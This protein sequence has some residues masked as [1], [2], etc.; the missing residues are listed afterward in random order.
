MRS[1]L[2][3]FGYLLRKKLI[4]QADFQRM[5]VMPQRGKGGDGGDKLGKIGPVFSACMELVESSQEEV[6][7]GSASCI[8]CNLL[9][10]TVS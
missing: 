7:M 2:Y 5:I 8:V 1:S 3:L 10:H 6:A 4:P 9:F